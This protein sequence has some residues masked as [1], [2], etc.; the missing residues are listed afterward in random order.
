MKRINMKRVVLFGLIVIISIISGL[1]I[2]NRETEYRSFFV[3]K[4]TDGATDILKDVT[5]DTQEQIPQRIN[6][7]TNNIYALDT[8]VGIGEKTAQ[9]IIDYRKENGD[10]EVIEDVMRVSGIGKKKFE[11]IKDFIYVAE[12]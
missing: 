7:N 12:E 2:Q 4:N 5:S 10:F 11:A 6:I 9:K 8:L 3:E 1:V